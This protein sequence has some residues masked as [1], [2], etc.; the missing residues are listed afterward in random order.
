MILAGKRILHA[1]TGGIAAYKGAELSRR[2]VQEGAVVR[3]VLTKAACKF[4]TPLTFRAIT[5]QEAATS[6]FDPLQN[7]PLPHVSLARE[8]DLVL[9]AP[10]TANILAKA[11]RGVADDL[12]STLLLSASPPIV[13][14]P[15]MDNMMYQNEATQENIR[16][17]R[18]RGLTV[19]QAGYGELAIGEQGW[20]RL[21]EIDDI[22]RTVED[23]LCRSTELKGRT[24]IVTAGATQEPLDMIRYV[25][26]RSTG[27]MGFALAEAVRNRAGRALLV[28]GP[29]GLWPPWGVEVM[30]VRTAEEMRST[31]RDHFDRAAAVIMAAAVMDFRPKV[32]R[33]GKDRPGERLDLESTADI[34]TE[35]GDMKGSQVLVGFAAETGDVVERAKS[36]LLAKNLDLI[37]ANDVTKPASGFGADDNEVMIIDRSLNVERLP[38]MSKKKLAPI[39]LD[40]LVAILG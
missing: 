11:A 37:I 3:A 29:T 20:G 30:P 14:V 33:D 27:K 2:L 28:S 22:L 36:K 40:R 24:V 31:V 6:L 19:M 32:V 15:A 18:G 39:V 34:L 4:V 1:V 23:S 26:N 25:T 17:L 21:P 38:L 8:A 13:L 7:H 5:G 16:I 35:L 9:V 10:A 12:L